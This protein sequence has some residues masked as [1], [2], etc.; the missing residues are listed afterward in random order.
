MTHNVVQNPEDAR[1]GIRDGCEE[2]TKIQLGKIQT[3]RLLLEKLRTILHKI[4]GKMILHGQKF[5][6]LL[7]VCIARCHRVVLRCMELRSGSGMVP[8]Y[9]CLSCRQ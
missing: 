8:Y 6:R 1:Y 9:F 3:T 4:I 2:N 5:A 7:Q